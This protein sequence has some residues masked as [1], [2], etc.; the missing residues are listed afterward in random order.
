MEVRYRKYDDFVEADRE[1]YVR[2]ADLFR[3]V[4]GRGA[5]VDVRDTFSKMWEEEA[6]AGLKGF[7]AFYREKVEVAE[8]LVVWHSEKNGVRVRRVWH[9]VIVTGKQ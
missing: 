2:T 3:E 6:P 7:E 4:Y 5:R 1:Y 8:E 9:V